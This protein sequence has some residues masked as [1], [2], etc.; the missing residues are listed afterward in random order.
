VAALARGQGS[1]GLHLARAAAAARPEGARGRVA[2]SFLARTP[3]DNGCAWV[4]RPSRCT[5]P[6]S[7]AGPGYPGPAG[8]SGRGRRRIEPE[9]PEPAWK[10]H[11]LSPH[12]LH[13]IADIGDPGAHRLEG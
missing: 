3:A 12:A 6:C 7:R 11:G 9:L 13:G 5:N 8:G 4:T 2:L 1:A 10:G